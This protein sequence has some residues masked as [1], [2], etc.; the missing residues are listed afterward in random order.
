M[1]NHKFCSGNANKCRTLGSDV[2]L[3]WQ[4]IQYAGLKLRR[5]GMGGNVCGASAFIFWPCI[6][7]H[8]SVLCWGCSSRRLLGLLGSAAKQI[9]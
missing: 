5:P 1:T 7:R 3:P 6:W 2:V 8:P 9:C 4:Q